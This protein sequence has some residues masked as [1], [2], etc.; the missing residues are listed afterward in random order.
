MPFRPFPGLYFILRIRED[1]VVRIRGNCH[2]AGKEKRIL[3]RFHHTANTSQLIIRSVHVRI[4]DLCTCTP[5]CQ[6]IFIIISI[7][8]RCGKFKHVA[9]NF[10]H[11]LSSKQQHF[12]CLNFIRGCAFLPTV[13]FTHIIFICITLIC[14]CSS[15]TI[16]YTHINLISLCS[17]Y[18]FATIGN[19][20]RVCINNIQRTIHIDVGIRNASAQHIR[21]RFGRI[22]RSRQSIFILIAG[23]LTIVISAIIVA[24]VIS[25][26]RPLRSARIARC[27]RSAGRIITAGSQ[28]GQRHCR[29]QNTDS[30]TFH[31]SHNDSSIF[32]EIA[33]APQ[34]TVSASR[35]YPPPPIC[36]RFFRNL[37][38]W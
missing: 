17:I 27:F 4:C 35:V 14:P 21:L 5:L 19:L 16:R 12:C 22:P 31:H 24:I 20:L 29:R 2:R 9:W 11:P 10:I 38:I 33:E 34:I 1:T 8:F 7:R 6:H 32:N 3:C 36:Q 30:E 37:A 13:S 26:A 25:A 18:H 15:C 23:L 28:H